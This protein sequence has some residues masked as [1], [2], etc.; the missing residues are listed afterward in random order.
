MI[1]LKMLDAAGASSTRVL[2]L[3]QRVTTGL[4]FYLSRFWLG[5][6]RCR[7]SV[8]HLPTVCTNVLHLSNLASHPVGSL[9]KHKLFVK[10][11]RLSQYYI[12]S[13]ST[14]KNMEKIPL[15]KDAAIC[16]HCCVL[17]LCIYIFITFS[18]F[19]RWWKCLKCPTVPQLCSTSTLSCLYLS[20]KEKMVL[21]VHNSCSILNPT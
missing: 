16:F 21:Y 2:W 13:L 19:C 4:S 12:V 6:Q 7:Q 9:S 18:F 15:G 11:T 20:W 14:S 8:K 5:E 17:P 10:L 3:I 1:A